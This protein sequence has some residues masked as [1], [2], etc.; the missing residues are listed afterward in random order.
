[1]TNVR[2]IGQSR[3]E[4]GVL[5]AVTDSTLVLAPIKREPRGCFFSL[6]SGPT[7]YP[8]VL[9]NL[10]YDLEVGYRK[11]VRHGIMISLGLPFTDEITG[12]APNGGFTTYLYLQ[13]R[14]WYASYRWAWFSTNGRLVGSVGPALL[15]IQDFEGI[16]SFNYSSR[17]TQVRPGLHMNGQF[18]FVNR[19]TWLAAAKV[20]ARWGL[21]TSTSQYEKTTLVS[22]PTGNQQKILTFPS[23]TT[24]TFH[25]NIGFQIGLKFL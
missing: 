2:L 1:V 11:S 18:R 21:P 20:D 17:H 8:R 5:F 23:L 10:S 4:T 22:T 25:V 3:Q 14:L 16:A 9:G 15:L 24:S 19:R 6:C 13:S 7:D 12:R